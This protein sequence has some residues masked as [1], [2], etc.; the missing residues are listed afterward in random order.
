M[1]AYWIARV[2]VSDPDAYAEYAKRATVALQS[3]GGRILARG[4]RVE[5]LEGEPYARNVVVEFPSFE[6][7][8]ACYNSPAY[9]EAKALQE[10]AAVRNLCIVEGL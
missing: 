6:Q 8:L 3:H 2:N 9:R 5:S 4:G 7:A 1:A 10:G